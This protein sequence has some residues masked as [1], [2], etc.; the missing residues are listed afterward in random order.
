MFF[1]EHIFEFDIEKI[2]K[3]LEAIEKLEEKK[4]YIHYLKKEIRKTRSFIRKDYVDKFKEEIMP[5]RDDQNLVDFFDESGEQIDEF[6]FKR[7][8]NIIEKI[9][10]V[11]L[12]KVFKEKIND[13]KRKSIGSLQRLQDS[14][15]NKLGDLDNNL[16]LELR[17][18]EEIE[19]IEKNSQIE[20]KHST[21][22]ASPVQND[23]DRLNWLLSFTDLA[24]LINDLKS[25]GYIKSTY[26]EVCEHFL[27]K[28]NSI[29]PSGLKDM[30]SK[31][32]NDFTDNRPSEDI[33]EIIDKQQKRVDKR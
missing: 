22:S 30:I 33:E 32:N 14:E 23:K 13:E 27:V 16:D 20:N 28:G 11:Y 4:F 7:I 15:M 12:R 19:D 21:Q 5:F 9:P 10:N 3:F 25:K 26:S 6:E 2:Q 1:N 18:I 8:K 29:K 17:Y 24:Y 31:I